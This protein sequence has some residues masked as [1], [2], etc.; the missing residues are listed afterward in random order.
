VNRELRFE[1]G[2]VTLVIIPQGE[3][4]RPEPS[5]ELVA[6]IE[7]QLAVRAPAG[8]VHSLP[9]RVNVIGPGWV[10]VAV[11]AD[12]VPRE[13]G[14]AE[15]VER[16]VVAALG[17]FLHPLTGGPAGAGW[18]LGRD[19]YAS[20]VAQVIERVPG[21]SHVTRLRLVPGA[22][23]RRL[24]F[25][26]SA[27]PLAR[28]AAPEGSRVATPDLRKAGRL[29]MP[30]AA[31]TLVD[32]LTLRGLK[33][34]DRLAVVLDL[35]VTTAGPDGRV[36]GMPHG[37]G[38]P[39]GFPVG[40][41][42]MT[43]DGRSSRLTQGLPRV[44]PSGEPDDIV[45]R[46]EDAVLSRELA[47]YTRLAIFAPSPMTVAAVAEGPPGSA[48]ATARLV[49]YDTDVSFPAGTVLAAP[50]GRVRVPLAADA[51][52]DPITGTIDSL[53]FEDFATGDRVRL[54]HPEYAAPTLEAVVEQVTTVDDLVYLDPNVCVYAKEHQI[55]MAG[56]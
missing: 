11:A 23:Q 17:R 14:Q 52:P 44:P 38:S 30:V 48:V 16:R 28:T 20:E 2:W 55:R 35:T 41:I 29:A 5:A 31:A 40:S 26:A 22:L 12:V 42:V 10:Q 37:R 21:V 43:P 27:A 18:E 49:P 7:Q 51:A 6:T 24:G 56:R 47:P 34:G 39:V 9:S 53:A 19:V 36:Q 13:L 33:Q 25:T 8:L 15:E 32:G 46:V 4:P 3:D 50:D 45:I 54:E 1:P